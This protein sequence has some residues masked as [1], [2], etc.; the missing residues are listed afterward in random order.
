MYGTKEGSGSVKVNIDSVDLFSNYGVLINIKRETP[1]S[2][3]TDLKEHQFII[4]YKKTTEKI[5]EVNLKIKTIKTIIWYDLMETKKKTVE[6][7]IKNNDVQYINVSVFSKKSEEVLSQLNGEMFVSQYTPL[8]RVRLDS[9]D[10]L[11][12]ELLSKLT[13]DNINVNISIFYK[14]ESFQIA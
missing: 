5:A 11:D 9:V 4:E 1:V 3:T 7:F 12:F 10:D 6:K 8:I 2:L 14:I 13:D